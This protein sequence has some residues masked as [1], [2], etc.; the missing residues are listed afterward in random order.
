MIKDVHITNLVKHALIETREE[1]SDGSRG[2]FQEL[3]GFV[4]FID[5]R[6]STQTFLEQQDRT[7][8]KFAHAF[9]AG[10]H[11][12]FRAYKFRE[13]SIKFLG[14]GILAIYIENLN[15]ES[16]NC[17]AYEVSSKI[18]FLVKEIIK[19]LGAKDNDII[20]G[21]RI[22]VVPT[23]KYKLYRGKTGIYGDSR[24]EY[25]GLAINQ[26]VSLTKIKYPNEPFAVMRMMDY[27]YS[28]IEYKQIKDG[29]YEYEL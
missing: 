12:I 27:N 10:V 29:V 5:I 25:N 20:D 2:K 17:P 16:F 28:N 18:V 7:Y 26:A 9:Y 3:S 19:H 8:L 21:I 23:N 14:D 11:K 6:N 24:I 22:S 15:K 13:D 1:K 4:F